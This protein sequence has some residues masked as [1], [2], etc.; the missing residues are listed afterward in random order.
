[1]KLHPDHTD[2]GPAFEAAE[3]LELLSTSNLPSAS[4]QLWMLHND[5]AIL[6]SCLML[7]LVCS[8]TVFM[9]FFVH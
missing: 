5:F 8:P 9:F 1:M 4:K 3:L 2:R 6:A 7:G